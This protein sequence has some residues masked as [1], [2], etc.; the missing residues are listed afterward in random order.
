MRVVLN[1]ML[2]RD[3]QWTDTKIRATSWLSHALLLD[4]K[5]ID[6]DERLSN[7]ENSLKSQFRIQSLCAK[8]CK[9]HAV[10]F[11]LLLI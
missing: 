5:H 9:C 2:S 3:M 4:Q 1:Y 11:F 10:G 8:S 7:T 6:R